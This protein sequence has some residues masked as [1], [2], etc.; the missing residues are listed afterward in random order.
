MGNYTSTKETNGL[1]F[2]EGKVFNAILNIMEN[3]K[4]EKNGVELD[5]TTGEVKYR[6]IKIG[7]LRVA[8]KPLLV[9]NKCMIRKVEAVKCFRDRKQSKSGVWIN[10]DVVEN[11]YIIQSMEDCSF[12]MGTGRGEGSGWGDSAVTLAE[13]DAFKNFIGNT[14]CLVTDEES[15]NV[16]DNNKVENT[17]TENEPV[18]KRKRRTKA[19]IEAE[20]EKES[21]N[22][23]N[24]VEKTTSE[25]KTE[26]VEEPKISNP[27]VKLVAPEPK[28]EIVKNIDKNIDCE[29]DNGVPVE[30]P[31]EAFEEAK[32]MDKPI[33]VEA[34]EPVEQKEEEPSED[35]TE[36]VEAVEEPKEPVEEQEIEEATEPTEEQVSSDEEIKAYA[37]II[38]P[39]Q[40]RHVNGKTFEDVCGM[41][42]NNVSEADKAARNCI[43]Y[44]SSH[45]ERFEEKAPE[46]VKACMLA[47]SKFNLVA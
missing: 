26:S 20:K 39:I 45:P 1:L 34:K 12:V 27:P 16:D 37:N 36:K 44:V 10:I 23:T 19:E 18:K 33:S 15:A 30:L 3:L 22:K 41:A 25:N 29:T 28:N 21:E 4:V 42:L 46:F 5:E 32:Q 43:I 11:S 35:M 8:L 24:E 14:F 40:N 13:A 7:D 31:K 2:K 9:Q 17:E 38:C 47:A 6:Y